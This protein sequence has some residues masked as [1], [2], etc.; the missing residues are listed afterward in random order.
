[1]SSLLVATVS[2]MR[3][4]KPLIPERTPFLESYDPD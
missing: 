4:G 2:Q 1:M 3:E